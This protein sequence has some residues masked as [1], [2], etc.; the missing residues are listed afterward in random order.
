VAHRRRVIPAALCALALCVCL[1]VSGALGT[2]GTP[3]ARA[4]A[5]HNHGHRTA[6]GHRGHRVQC[7][8][9]KPSAHAKRRPAHANRRS[10]R[11]KPTSFHSSAGHPRHSTHPAGCRHVSKRHTTATHHNSRHPSV[12]R[13]T[14]RSPAAAHSS[15]CPD[16]DIRPNEQNLEQI[17]AATLCLVNRERTGQGESPLSDNAHLDQSAQAHTEDMAFGGY[18]EHVGPHG[19]TPLSRMRSAGYIYSSNIGYEVGEN[20]A[21]GTLWLATPRSIVAGWMASPGHRENIL[22]V[23]FRDTGVGVSPHPPSALAR[24]QAG[25]IYTEDFGVIIT[26]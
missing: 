2:R 14:H 17:R 4:G 23:R 10:R 7:A 9:T 11:A 6:R 8:P 24:G 5:Y 26:H 22:D 25:G 21:W 15:S 19:D 3:V 20:I 12:H 1:P 18:V 13:P 16:A